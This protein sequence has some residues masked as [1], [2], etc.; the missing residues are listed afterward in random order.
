MSNRT[1]RI[2]AALA[3]TAASIA[4][5]F[6]LTAITPV[7]PSLPTP[8]GGLSTLKI[9]F[10]KIYV[11]PTESRTFARVCSAFESPGTVRLGG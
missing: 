1:R 11:S 7:K 9:C 4:P 2:A 8:S 5:A 6:A 10:T 3:L